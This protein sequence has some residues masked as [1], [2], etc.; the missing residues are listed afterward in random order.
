MLPL[1]NPPS[2]LRCTWSPGAAALRDKGFAN[3]EEGE[4]TEVGANKS[5]GGGFEHTQPNSGVPLGSQVWWSHE[6]GG[7]AL[8]KIPLRLGFRELLGE[9]RSPGERRGQSWWVGRGDGK[10]V[11]KT[12][13]P[14]GG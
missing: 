1:N 9:S 14:S 10:E 13:G 12:G 8:Q 4:A 2:G 7:G 6:C 3:K 11:P 5:G